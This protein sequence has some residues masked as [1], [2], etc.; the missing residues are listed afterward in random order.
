MTIERRDVID[1]VGKKR[2]TLEL[3]IIDHL[4]WVWEP[5]HILMLQAKLNTY[6]QYIEAEQYKETY[7]NVKKFHI[8]IVFLNG[9]TEKCLQFLRVS[10][11]QLDASPLNVKLDYEFPP[12]AM[13]RGVV[14]GGF[15]AK[16]FDI[17]V[18]YLRDEDYPVDEVLEAMLD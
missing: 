13:V 8:T 11:A 16:S 3:M 10:Q 9:V 1:M 7:G 15:E 2:R 12:D 6:L 5:A 18:D 4:D 14:E 17:F